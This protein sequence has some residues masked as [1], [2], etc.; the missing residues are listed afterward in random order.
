MDKGVIICV[1]MLARLSGLSPAPKCSYVKNSAIFISSR[2]RLL[3]AAYDPTPGILETQFAFDLQGL[4]AAV[5]SKAIVDN[6]TDQATAFQV[7]ILCTCT[8]S[9]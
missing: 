6:I 2:R 5:V 3:A 4:K 1:A 9:P 7:S 8:A